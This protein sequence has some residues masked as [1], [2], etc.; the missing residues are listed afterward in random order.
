M[1][2]S[3]LASF[4]AAAVCLC[5]CCSCN[6]GGN[7]GDGE[8]KK[9]LDERT[10]FAYKAVPTDAILILDFEEFS[11]LEHLVND[12]S[13]F[14]GG[15]TDE[16]SSLVL[17]EKKLLNDKSLYGCHTLLTLHYSSENEV[18]FLGVIDVS[19]SPAAGEAA[20]SRYLDSVPHTER[21][22]NGCKLRA[23]DNGLEATS[24]GNLLIFSSSSFVLES[25]VRHL[26]NGSS[27]LDNHDFFSALEETGGDECIYLNHKQ[28][29]KLFSGSATYAF[30]KYS[31]FAMRFANW[32]ALKINLKQT[33][34]ISFESDECTSDD[35]SNFRSIF[36]SQTP[37]ESYAGKILPASTVFCVCLNISNMKSYLK[38]YGDYLE[39]NKKASFKNEKASLEWAMSQNFTELVSAFCLI[40]G[41]YEWLTFVR[42]KSTAFSKLFGGVKDKLEAPE[43][44]IFKY[45][46]FIPSLFGESFSHCKEDY[47][48]RIGE[49]TIIG[50]KRAIIEYSKGYRGFINLENYLSG[51]PASSFFGEKSSAGVYVNLKGGADTLLSAFNPYF[52]GLLEKGLKSKN[53]EC[54]TIS[55]G[56]ADENAAVNLSYCAARLAD[57]PQMFR[58]T[59]GAESQH[60]ID[61]TIKIS[62]GP[63]R[64]IDPISGD[65]N[66]VEQSRKY[67]SIAFL[68]KDSSGIWAVPLKDTIRGAVC[69]VQYPEGKVNMVFILSDKLYLMSKRG[70]YAYGYPV[71]LPKRVVYGPVV[72]KEGENW[73]VLVLG[74]DNVI[75][76]YTL[77]GKPVAGWKDIHAPEFVKQLPSEAVFFGKRYLVLRTVNKTRI[78]T[79]DGKEVTAKNW[80]KP[81]G[82]NSKLVPVS[83]G[84]I[85]VMGVDGKEFMLNLSSGRIK[86]L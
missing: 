53:F 73:S 46:G 75:S 43:T 28:I 7:K 50:P 21:M 56:T 38:D 57:E 3:L 24:K 8:E 14:A 59:H 33:N 69:Q 54:A 67:L 40:G 5:I 51:T 2:Q 32:S 85:K 80:R 20:L 25:S 60:F 72:L 35:P 26:S 15:I 6:G 10:E 48:C 22:Y 81:I 17:F 82:R 71:T 83:D 41:K 18:S 19:S 47:F 9:V 31:D 27:I 64:L 45:R 11:H 30:L 68:K 62:L 36:L 13:A 66:Y 39:V 37:Q 58:E 29:G 44:G 16:A 34:F 63:F 52:R 23:L 1:S 77:D 86:K 78:Y 79:L 70:G 49:W 61:S 4:F 42:K 76:R 65:T 12:T 55:I 74:W 84:Y